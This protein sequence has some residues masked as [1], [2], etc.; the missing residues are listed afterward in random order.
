MNCSQRCEPIEEPQEKQAKA[1]AKRKKNCS[2]FAA[3]QLQLS[4]RDKDND[5][6]EKLTHVAARTVVLHIPSAIE[7]DAVVDNLPCDIAYPLYHA[8][9]RFLFMNTMYEIALMSVFSPYVFICRKKRAL[10]QFPPTACPPGSASLANSAGQNGTGFSVL[11]CYV[12]TITGTT[13]APVVE[14]IHRR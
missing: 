1:C 4:S 2:G 14:R 9:A 10:I 6:I 13:F 7:F 12:Q 3:A 11:C 8:R 5:N